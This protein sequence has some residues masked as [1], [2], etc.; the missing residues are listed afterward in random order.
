MCRLGQAERRP[1]TDAARTCVGSSASLDPTYEKSRDAPSKTRTSTPSSRRRPRRWSCRSSRLE[2]AIKAN[3]AGDAAARQDGGRVRAA[4][5]GR[6]GVRV[7]GLSR[8]DA[9]GVSGRDRR[10][11]A[12]RHDER[13]GRWSRRRSRASPSA[14]ACSTAFTAV[15]RERALAKARADRCR[16][17]ARRAARAAGRRAVR[18][19]EPVRRRRAC[20]RWPAPR[21][22]ASMRPPRPTP[23]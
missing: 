15:T 5:R 16:Q 3:L 4:G 14:I 2:P 13:G 6:A 12:R 9:V 20:R 11:R 22:T 19:Q 17:G 18:G 7:R 8:C 21:S 10:G 1:N 23:R